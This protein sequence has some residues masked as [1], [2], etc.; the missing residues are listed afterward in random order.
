[1]FRW[2]D[3]KINN[4]MS[5]AKLT[6]NFTAY[7][8]LAASIL[9]MTFF[10]VCTPNQDMGG[11]LRGNA[12]E[13]GSE[14]IK[15]DEFARVYTRFADQYQRAYGE[16]FDAAALGLPKMVLDRLVEQKIFYL[17]AKDS[18]FLAS[19]EE[20]S[21]EILDIEAF[22][23]PKTGKFSTEQLNQI[24]S[25]N[26]YTEA[27]FVEEMR[28]VSQYEPPSRVFDGHDLYIRSGCKM[29]LQVRKLRA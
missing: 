18:G 29:G 23:D 7:A 26:R 3:K 16:S 24:M 2:K 6:R 15:A 8:I 28:G 27:S 11:Q 4:H 1:M 17:L 12:A 14:S 9:A 21:Q 10:G 19:D 5:G 22:K 25:S 20:V 13:V